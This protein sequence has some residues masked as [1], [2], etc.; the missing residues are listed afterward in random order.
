M[1]KFI[2]FSTLLISF[3][4]LSAQKQRLVNVYLQGQLQLVT[5]MTLPCSDITKAGLETLLVPSGF[6]CISKFVIKLIQC[7]VGIDR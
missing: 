4:Q 3:C 6:L 2:T 7:N 1:R 5:V